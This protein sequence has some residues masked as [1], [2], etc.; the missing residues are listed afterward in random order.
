[1][2]GNCRW[3]LGLE[4]S[5]PRHAPWKKQAAALPVITVPTITMDGSANGI[6]PATDGKAQA[7]KFRGPRTHRIVD[8][9]HKLPQEAPQAFT[10]AVWTLASAHRK[11][12]GRSIVGAA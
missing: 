5:D 7:G 8:A 11:V 10:D 6:T 12:A 3:R 1:M 2:I 4:P 9:G